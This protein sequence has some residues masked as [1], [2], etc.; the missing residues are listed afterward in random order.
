MIPATL[1]D[2]ALEAIATSNGIYYRIT[3]E[4]KRTVSVK[5]RGEKAVGGRFL[6]LSCLSYDCEH[7]EYVR[8]RS[9]A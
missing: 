6:C 8:E 5:D 9:H 7:S 3:R 4:A 2:T 1:R